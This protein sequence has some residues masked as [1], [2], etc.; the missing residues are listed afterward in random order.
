MAKYKE[1]NISH[2]DL[3]F[4][5]NNYRFQDSPDFVEAEE[6][7]FHEPSV[8]R[9]AYRS[10]RDPSLLQLK[11]SIIRNGLLP[12]EKLL[13]RPYRKTKGKY[14][15]AEG[16][17]RLAAMR[18]IVE[19]DEAGVSVPKEVLSSLKEIPVFILG[20]DKSDPVFQE[21]V[22]GVRHVSGIKQWGGYQRAKLVVS[23]RD[24]FNLDTAEVAGRLAMS[25]L[26][27]NRRYRA[28]KALEQMQNHEEY[29]HFAHADM[30]PIFHEGVAQPNVRDWLGW[31]D[32]ACEFQDE[33]ELENFYRLITPEESEE[34]DASKPKI[35]TYADVRDLRLILESEEAKTALL[36]P[37]RSIAD[38]LAIAKGPELRKSWKRQVTAAVDALGRIGVPELKA[39]KKEDLAEIK[40]LRDA[41]DELLTSH[42]TL[43]KK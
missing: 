19:D 14:V 41:A 23:L 8:Q 26:E 22:L 1:E 5:P 13:V 33:T 6:D 38:A 37:S 29:G 15:V 12:F 35:T 39:L 40:K 32:D 21:A 43:T 42:Q 28:F 17:R 31:D 16:N 25:T 10:L 20:N 9:K 24:D 18:W 30:Y 3:L 34:T 27:V 4:D 7:R 36:D 11:N 2:E